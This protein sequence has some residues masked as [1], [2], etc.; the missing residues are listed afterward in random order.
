MTAFSEAILHSKRTIIVFVRKCTYSSDEI[1]YEIN[2]VI[3][4]AMFVIP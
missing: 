2:F 3:F 1:Q 4:Y